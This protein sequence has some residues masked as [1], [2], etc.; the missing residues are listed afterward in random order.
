MIIVSDTTCLSHLALIGL[1]E[2]LPALFG[3]VVIPPAVAA[4]L[5][6]GQVK[7]QVI[8]EVLHSPWIEVRTLDDEARTD[9]LAMTL[10]RGE[11]EAIVLAMELNCPLLMDDLPGRRCAQSLMLKI[12]GTLGVLVAAKQRGLLPLVQPVI[13]RMIH[14]H[15][16]RAGQALLAQTLK[17]A[18]E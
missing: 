17:E 2:L 4:E 5:S 12:T 9:E 11:A 3:S 16:F 6:R 13:H 18:G 1:H 14:E 10:D 7:H 8:G 15:D